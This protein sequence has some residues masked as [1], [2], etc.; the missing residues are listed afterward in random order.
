M[1]RVIG[2]WLSQP[3]PKSTWTSRSRS[4]SWSCCDAGALRGTR[5]ERADGRVELE[6][7]DLDVADRRE[8]GDY[9]VTVMMKRCETETENVMQEVKFAKL[10]LVITNLRRV[11]QRDVKVKVKA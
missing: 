5:L 10:L 8:G 1:A 6:E 11:A 7:L 4:R 3:E 2:K 9:L